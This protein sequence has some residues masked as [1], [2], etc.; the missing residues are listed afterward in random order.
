MF[1]V[2]GE[3]NLDLLESLRVSSIDV[4]ITRNE[5][6]AVFMAANYGRLTGKAG[7]ALA[8]LGPGA[9]NMVT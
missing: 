8:T 1:G 5:Q 7:V 3:E 4:I 6:T 9:T 2:P